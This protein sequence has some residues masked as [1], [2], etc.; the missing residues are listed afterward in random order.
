VADLYYIEEG[1][2]DAG[3]FV[4]TADAAAAVSSTSSVTAVVGKNQSIDLV[5]FQTASVSVTA[6]RFRTATST[7]TSTSSVAA[8][9]GKIIEQDDDLTLTWDD[10]SSWDNIPSDQWTSVGVWLQAPFTISALLEEVTGEAVFGEGAW[11]SEFTQTVEGALT[12]S[13]T[14]A[15]ASEFSQSASALANKTAEAAILSTATQTG[16]KQL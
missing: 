14:A 9:V 4:Y 10:L 2:Y 1:Y 3:Y 8:V 15:L 16:T 5:A 12:K 13:T 11:S 7:A 6:E